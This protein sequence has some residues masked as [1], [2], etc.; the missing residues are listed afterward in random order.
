M[1]GNNATTVVNERVVCRDREV[2]IKL[3]SSI[4]ALLRSY[5]PETK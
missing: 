3:D 1:V 2:L 5:L 4:C